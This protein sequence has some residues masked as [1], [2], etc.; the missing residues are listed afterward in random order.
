MKQQTEIKMENNLEKL[1]DLLK[2]ATITLKYQYVEFNEKF[3][4][5]EFSRIKKWIEDYR[6]DKIDRAKNMK[7]YWNLPSYLLTD[8][9]PENHIE[10]ARKFAC[11]HYH[12]SIL[13]LAIR[14]EKYGLNV[15]K[16]VVTAS[17]IGVN[18]DCTLTDGQK[19][20]RAFTI[21]ASGDVQRPHYRFLIK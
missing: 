3:A 18:L 12:N 21:V 19:T 4:E 2:R 6:T 8:Q 11:D 16:L 9:T 20:I 17:H 14:V 5:N 13:K 15:E 1:T 7:K 10:K